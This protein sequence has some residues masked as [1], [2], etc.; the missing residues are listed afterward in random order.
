VIIGSPFEVSTALLE[1]IHKVDAVVH[2]KTPVSHPEGQD[3]YK[4]KY[5]KWLINTSLFLGSKRTWNL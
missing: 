2:G 4:V 3:P 1:K 5:M